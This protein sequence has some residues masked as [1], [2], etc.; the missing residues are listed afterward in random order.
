MLFIQLCKL[1]FLVFLKALTEAITL[2]FVGVYD[3]FIAQADLSH[4]IGCF[5][6]H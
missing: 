3:Y 1:L 4:V 5:T 2:R 6:F